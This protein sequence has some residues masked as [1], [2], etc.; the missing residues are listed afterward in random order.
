MTIRHKYA[1]TGAINLITSV[2][3][4]FSIRV[5]DITGVLMLVLLVLG[6]LAGYAT[7]AFFISAISRS[8]KKTIRRFL[9]LLDE[10]FS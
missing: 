8:P 1:I 7:I 4:F 2:L 6:A 3:C 5:Y 9:H 10:I